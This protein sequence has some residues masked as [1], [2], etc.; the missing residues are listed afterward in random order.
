[1][2]AHTIESQANR[3]IKV[4]LQQELPKC[5]SRGR[6]QTAWLIQESVLDAWRFS[7][8]NPRLQPRQLPSVVPGM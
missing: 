4:R 3:A 7:E 1:M 5:Y 6:W 8:P 2:I